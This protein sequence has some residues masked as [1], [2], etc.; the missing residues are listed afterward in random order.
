MLAN[1]QSLKRAW[2]DYNK[3]QD[4]ATPA[5]ATHLSFTK[6]SIKS[7]LLMKEKKKKVEKS[8]TLPNS[9]Q[10]AS[11]WTRIWAQVCLQSPRVISNAR[12]PLKEE[13]SREVWADGKEKGRESRLPLRGHRNAFSD[14]QGSE[15]DSFQVTAS[16]KTE[17][18]LRYLS[19]RLALLQELGGVIPSVGGGR[20]YK[21]AG[22]GHEFTDV[23]QSFCEGCK[24]YWSF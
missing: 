18:V 23:C 11:T 4:L 10:S 22:R 12:M 17:R 7:V 13:G 6:H 24:L 9:P 14:I 1:V 2:P 20:D 16:K 15:W 5:F 3:N 19:P 21:W 8:S